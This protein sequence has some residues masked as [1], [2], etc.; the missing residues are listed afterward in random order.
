MNTQ[1][2]ATLAPLKDLLAMVRLKSKKKKKRDSLKNT[3]D[4]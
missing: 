4:N 1:N 2:Q 3:R